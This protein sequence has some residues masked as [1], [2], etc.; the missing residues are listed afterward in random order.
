MLGGSFNAMLAEGALIVSPG[1][2]LGTGHDTS[3]FGVWSSGDLDVSDEIL[4]CALDQ[5]DVDAHR[6]YTAGCSGISPTLARS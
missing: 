6:I 2:A 5:L 3:G 1:A 4:G